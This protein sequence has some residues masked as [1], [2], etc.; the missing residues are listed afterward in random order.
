MILVT[1]ATGFLGKRVCRRLEQSAREFSRT[2]LSLGTDLRNFDQTV[3]LFQSVRPK[4]VLNCA[5]FAGG[6]QFGLKYPADIFRN[7][8]PMIA[9]LFEAAHLAGVQRIVNPLANCVY[10]AQLTLFEESRFWDGPLHDS[11]MVY[12]LLRKISWAGS[13]AYAR[14]RG[15][16]T[17]NLVLSNMYG[18]EDHFDQER[19]HALGALV[20]KF[21]AAKKSGAPE[22]IVWG[23]GTQVRE[24]LYVD[25]G[26]E[27]MV[28]GIDCAPCVE[29]VN[30]GVA[31]GASIAD[32]AERIRAVV[33]Y[34]GRIV[35]DNSKPD[36]A[37]FKTVDGSH[38][39]ALLGWSPQVRLGEGLRRTVQ[40]YREN[41]GVYR[42]LPNSSSITSR[43]ALGTPV[44]ASSQNTACEGPCST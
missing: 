36:G 44:S 5:S 15:L 2:S 43:V 8:M 10:P 29:P 33:E 12:G 22:V 21:I 14:Q 11:V 4:A 30:V 9:N 3:A 26:A 25:D 24:W 7:N 18:P 19:S 38:G 41:E 28:R 34:E 32:L 37:P 42:V 40:W 16:Q 1:G 20:L 17:I 6:I 27:A 31:K 35:Y 13:W 39:K 23:T